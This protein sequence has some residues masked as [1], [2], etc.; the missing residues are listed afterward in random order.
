MG[1]RCEGRIFCHSLSLLDSHDTQTTVE[2]QGITGLEHRRSVSGARDAGK[3][4]LS[5]NNGPVNQHPSPSLH[6]GGTRKNQKGH[7]G[8]QGVISKGEVPALFGIC[9]PY[10]KFPL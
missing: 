5:L 2:R 3:A 4:V 6:D 8:K 1:Y 10:S 9:S 7:A